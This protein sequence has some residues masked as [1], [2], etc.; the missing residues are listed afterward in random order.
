MTLPGIGRRVAQ[1][2][3]DER[4]KN[5]RYVACSDLSRVKGIGPA[6]VERLELLCRIA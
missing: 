6:I 5:G 3:I 2:I 4:K 1:R